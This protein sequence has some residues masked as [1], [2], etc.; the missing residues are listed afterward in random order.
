MNILTISSAICE[1]FNCKMIILLIAKLD[2][3]FSDLLPNRKGLEKLNGSK[4]NL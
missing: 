4:L 3:I 1:A 2:K